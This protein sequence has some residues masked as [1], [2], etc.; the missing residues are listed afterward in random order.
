MVVIMIGR[1]GAL[2]ARFQLD[3]DTAGVAGDIDRTRP[4][5][6]HEGRHIGILGNDA[7]QGLLMLLHGLEGDPLCRFGENEDLASVFGRQEPLGH[8]HKQVPCG[9]QHQPRHQHR[10]QAMA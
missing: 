1:N 4:D 8:V 7:G 9:Y 2:T 6:R 3:E 10:H 5:A